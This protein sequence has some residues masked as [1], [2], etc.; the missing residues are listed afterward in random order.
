L[1]SQLVLSFTSLWL[2]LPSKKVL[3]IDVLK[4]QWS[5]LHVNVYSAR[6]YLCRSRYVKKERYLYICSQ[7]LAMSRASNDRKTMPGLHKIQPKVSD[8]ISTSS[9]NAMNMKQVEKPCLYTWERITSRQA[10]L[11]L[12][13]AQVD[14]ISHADTCKIQNEL[15]RS[16]K[17]SN[18]VCIWYEKENTCLLPCPKQLQKLKL[19]NRKDESDIP[20][21]AFIYKHVK[22]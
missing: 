5:G 22:L 17:N 6:L 9:S 15:K 4:I 18:L 20:H 14:K 10:V 13:K 21:Q 12:D 2:T 11:I 16:K 19:N 7:W 8:I 3:Q 1:K